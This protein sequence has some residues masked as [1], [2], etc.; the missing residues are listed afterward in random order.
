MGWGVGRNIIIL[1][2]NVTQS[3][4]YKV[5]GGGQI[6]KK[7]CRGHLIGLTINSHIYARRSN[8]QMEKAYFDSSL[9][10]KCVQLLSLVGNTEISKEGQLREPLFGPEKIWLKGPVLTNT[11]VR[12]QLVCCVPK[13][14]TE[15]IRRHISPWKR[16]H[17][18]IIVYLTK[19]QFPHK[20]A[21]CK[22]QVGGLS[23]LGVMKKTLH[24]VPRQAGWF[25]Q[26]SFLY[27][28]L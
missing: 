23:L 7:N 22:A 17:F 14:S 12:G 1:A 18:L 28:Y 9:H 26:V 25:S 8:V 16:K 15:V 19:Q 13:P 2:D 27:I 3:S 24:Q 5:Y 11:R 21:V 4:Y 6:F 20:L 10:K